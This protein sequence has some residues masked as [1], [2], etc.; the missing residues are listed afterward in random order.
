MEAQNS[1]TD[2]IVVGIVAGDDNMDQ[3][4]QRYHNTPA[5]YFVQE[6]GISGVDQ[7]TAALQGLHLT[8]L[9]LFVKNDSQALY[10]SGTPLT[11]ANATTFA[12]QFI[13]W[14]TAISGKIVIHNNNNTAST[15]LIA[16]MN[17]LHELTNLTVE[18]KY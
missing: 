10:I 8:D 15:D 16:L 7:I 2:F 4:Q 1:T 11:I 17:K 14:Q 9:H 18:Q 5:V 6:S 12:S 3:I 13:T